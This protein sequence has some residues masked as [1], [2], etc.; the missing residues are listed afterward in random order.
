MNKRKLL[1]RRNK[2]H[3]FRNEI[4]QF[5]IFLI[6]GAVLIL[7]ICGYMIRSVTS[8]K[9]SAGADSKAAVIRQT[10]EISTSSEVIGSQSTDGN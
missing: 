4:S 7:L 8:K 5:L 1:S 2:K 3:S 9:N 10:E 6:S